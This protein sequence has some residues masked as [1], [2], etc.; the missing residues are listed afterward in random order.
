MALYAEKKTFENGTKK[1]NKKYMVTQI[2]M[3]LKFSVKNTGWRKYKG[4]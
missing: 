1:L 4:T 2:Q 3:F